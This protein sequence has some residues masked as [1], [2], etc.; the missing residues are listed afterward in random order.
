[1]TTGPLHWSNLQIGRALDNQ[2]FVFSISPA[3]GDKGYIA[4]GHS[5]VTSPWGR[6]LVEA[7]AKEEIV[8]A[9]INIEECRK[10][11]QQ[12]PIFSQRRVDL[13]DTNAKL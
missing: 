7:D 9:D 4:Y 3:R 2:V 1:M 6:I 8:Y 5:Q 10:V 13:Y 12:I 11:R